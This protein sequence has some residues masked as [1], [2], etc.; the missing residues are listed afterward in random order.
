MS[1]LLSSLA[2]IDR[3]LKKWSHVN[4]STKPAQLRGLHQNQKA[5][6]EHKKHKPADDGD[7]LKVIQRLRT[8]QDELNDSKKE[9]CQKAGE[10]KRHHESPNQIYDALHFV[11][12]YWVD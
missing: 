1:L 7:N 8:P 3:L 2:T 11:P 12:F 4:D 5:G 9:Y 10:L 6:G